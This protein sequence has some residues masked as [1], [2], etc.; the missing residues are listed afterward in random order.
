M[1]K[2]VRAYVEEMLPEWRRRYEA[3]ETLTQIAAGA[4]VSVS[5]I[6]NT[7]RAAGVTMRPRGKAGLDNTKPVPLDAK[8]RAARFHTFGMSQREAASAA[9]IS[10]GALQRHLRQMERTA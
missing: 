2:L 3:G 1:S 5:T 9:G 4:D 8:V 7:L 6:Y 10:L